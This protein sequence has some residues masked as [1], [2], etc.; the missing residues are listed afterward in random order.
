MRNARTTG[1]DVGYILLGL[2]VILV[3]ATGVYLYTQVRTDVI[4]RAVSNEELLRAAVIVHDGDTLLAAEALFYHPVT[5]KGAMFD[6]QGDVGVLISSRNRYDRI[7]SVFDP[8]KPRAFVDEME[9]VLG[10]DI[11]YYLMMDLSQLEKMVDLLEGVDL[12]IPNAIETGDVLLPSGSVTL[13]GRKAV[14]YMTYRGPDE[15]DGEV[16]GRRQKL[17]QAVIHA[18]GQGALEHREVL[19]VM[20]RF[21]DSNLSPR[22]MD[23]FWTEVSRMDVDRMVVQRSLGTKRAIEEGIELLFLHRE[24]KWLQESVQ[25]TLES[26]ANPDVQADG[27]I[28]LNL[29]ILNGTDR[30]GLAA[31]TAVI[32][33]NFGFDVVEI[34]NADTN[35]YDRTVIMDHTGNPELVRRVGQIIRANYYVES[36]ALDEVVDVTIILGKDFDGNYVKQ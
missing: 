9:D 20:H 18:M 13:D 35:D 30:N 5:V 17:L 19:G 26:L 15:G 33:R 25:H 31:R 4:T 6:I 12:F 34:G 14:Q 24:G 22:A 36:E 1:F 21:V 27:P 8:A 16:V 11:P 10:V 3:T 7:D 32:Y 23:A 2:I 29:A 28:Q